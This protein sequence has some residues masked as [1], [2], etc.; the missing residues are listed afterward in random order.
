MRDTPPIVSVEALATMAGE[1]R[2]L[3]EKL[4]PLGLSIVIAGNGWR[5]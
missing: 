4:R 5:P 2:A 3:E 1:L